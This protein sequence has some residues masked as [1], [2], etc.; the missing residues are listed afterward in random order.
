MPDTI[1]RIAVPVPVASGLTWP[2][3][4]SSRMVSDFGY[5][6][7]RPWPIIEH[8]FGEAATLSYQRFQ[9]GIGPRKFPFRKQV[10]S[11]T[12]RSNLFEFFE[13]VEGSFQT[14]TYNAPQSD[15]ATSPYTVIFETQPLSVSELANACQSGF[16]FIEC[17]NPLSAP[18]YPVAATCLRFP[19]STLQAAL[20]SQVQ[21]IIPLIH[22]RVRETAVPDIYLSDRRCTVGTQLYLPRIIGLGEPGSD[23]IM[24]QSIAD[25]MRGTPADNVQFTFGNADRVMGQLANDTDLKYASIDLCLYHVQSQTILQLWKGSII[26]FVHD[27]SAQFTVQCTDGLYQVNMLYPNRTISRQCWKTFD[28]G[29]WCPFSTQGSIQTGTSSAGVTFAADR[30]SCDYYFDSANGCQAHG[31]SPLLTSQRVPEKLG[32]FGGHPAQ[33][34]GVN[35]LNNATGFAG[36]NRNLVTAT[37]LVSDSMWGNALADIWCNDGSAGPASGG[38]QGQNPGKAFF[39]N[40]VVA[41]VRDEGDFFDMIGIVGAGPLGL[42][43]GWSVYTNADGYKYIVAPLGDG[44]P[45]QGFSVDSQLNVKTSVDL[46]LREVP[47]ADPQ[48]L[49]YVDDF[50]N[51]TSPSF[52]LGQTAPGSNPTYSVWGPQTAAGTA[53]VELRYA[54]PSGINPTIPEQHSMTVPIAQGLQGLVYNAANPTG[55]NYAGLTNPFWVAANTYIR[56]LSMQR[57]LTAAVAFLNLPSLYA[58]D[59]T[60]TGEIADKPVHP[61]VGDITTFETQFQFQGILSQQKPLRDQLTEIL[62][63]ALGFFIFEFGTIKFGIRENASAVSAFTLGN[64]LFRSLTLSPIEANFERLIINYADQAYQYQANTAEYYDKDHANYFNR[65][66]SP[67]TASQHIVGCC[68]LSQGLRLAATRTREEVG[69]IR[70]AFDTTNQFRE[71]SAARKATWKT[72]ILALE[73]EAGQVVSMTHPDVPGGYDVDAWN[74]FRLT[75]PTGDV[76]GAGLVWDSTTSHFRIQ[77]WTLHKDWSITIQAKTVT[78]SMYDLVAGPKPQD[79][80]PQPLPILYYPEPLG[81][82]SPYYVQALSTDAVYPS[83][84]TF[85]TAQSYQVL[86]DG[87]IQVN[88]VI[89]GNQPINQYIP[90]CVPPEIKKGFVKSGGGTPGLGPGPTYSVAVCGKND[91]TGQVTPPS[92]L[93]IIQG[94]YS[95]TIGNIDWPQVTGITSYVMFIGVVNGGLDD[96]ITEAQTGTLSPNGNSYAPV[97]IS[98]QAIFVRT[99]KPARTTWALPNSNVQKVRIKGKILIHGGVLGAAIDTVSGNQIVSSECVD[100]AGQDNW[101]GRPLMIIGRLNG[102]TPFQNFTITGFDPSTGTFTL[103]RDASMLQGGGVPKFYTNAQVPTA[104]DTF[105][106]CF[107]G[108]D[109]SG[110]PNLITD[111]GLSNATNPT[112]PH[113]GLITNFEVGEI[114]RVIAGTNR[115]QTAQIVANNNISWTLDQPIQLGADSIWVVEERAWRSSVDSTPIKNSVL[116]TLSKIV[117]PVANYQRQQMMLGGFTVDVNN[118]EPGELDAPFRMIYIYGTGGLQLDRPYTWG[119]WDSTG[120]ARFLPVN[121]RNNSVAIDLVFEILDTPAIDEYI[122]IIWTNRQTNVTASIF[123]APVKIPAGSTGQI[124]TA[125]FASNPITFNRNDRLQFNQVSGDGSGTYSAILQTAIVTP[126]PSLTVPGTSSITGSGTIP[127]TGNTAGAGVPLGQMN[128]NSNSPDN[129]QYIPVI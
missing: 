78:P 72:T 6:M 117:F 80:L 37:S 16:N 53:F 90:N 12:D 112:K 91:T 28:D 30:N 93:I 45:P 18:V 106:V 33:P 8:R 115:G 27:G 81:Q 5:G 3:S 127:G 110:N 124:G 14:F 121:V 111:A 83:E 26:N 13:A 66:G 50:A 75:T 49:S 95:F 42:Y 39:V 114:I 65:G 71:F 101:E 23:V 76:S 2:L 48:P 11:R 89:T 38:D 113:T 57:N 21:Q 25:P 82:W 31:M 92:D 64:I 108:Y 87:T 24:T 43:E 103:D 105:V 96:Q 107:Q 128:F 74:A 102:S 94:V 97:N 40:A 70:Q 125:A 84:Y 62:A 59:G 9:V 60:A 15:H 34:Q 122:D 44:F 116:G 52:S 41:D 69:G 100:V 79:V 19:N 109:N 119:V 56:A 126:V 55:T 51:P 104:G 20:L 7:D 35:I 22:I 1:G 58:G 32:F 88:V 129:S 63:C 73:T 61:L 99:Y 54:K 36:F 98:Y 85:D 17:P 29:V 47:G 4:V 10:I 46:G 77:K 123:P 68:T 86:G 118:V 67:L 120:S